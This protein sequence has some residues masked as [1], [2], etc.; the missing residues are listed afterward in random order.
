MTVTLHEW[1]PELQRRWRQALAE[2]SADR[3]GLTVDLQMSEQAARE[4]SFS[5]VLRSA[6][7]A[8][9]VPLPVIVA[10]SGVDAILLGAFLR[11]EQPLTTDQVDRLVRVLRLEL[12]PA[13]GE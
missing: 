5:G 6:I 4:E 7:Q 3:A 9:G 12:A 10:R 1:T 8:G 2:T 11:G 13:V